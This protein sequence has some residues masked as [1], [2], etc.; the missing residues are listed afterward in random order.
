MTRPAATLVDLLRRRADDCGERVAF[1]FLADGEREA[2]S[3]TYGELDRRAR[4]LALRLGE[5]LPAGGRAILAFPPGLEFLAAFFGCLYA[6]VIAVPVPPAHP[7]RG[8]ERL[9][10]VAQD[11]E[12]G[13]VLGPGDVASD[14]GAENWRP[15][16]LDS[17]QLALLQYTSG[18]T[19]APRGVKISHG[20]IL[21]N[22]A[23][24]QAAQ[25]TEAASRSV[26]WLP[27][28]HDM[29]L[30][31]GLLAPLHGAY[32]AW[33]MS[34]AAFLN[35]TKFPGTTAKMLNKL[36]NILETMNWWRRHLKIFV[37]E[38]GF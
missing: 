29:G 25:A 30:I 32:P 28:Y 8:S 7:R 35:R 21:A 5:R 27:H 33:L 26:C 9:D 36:W 16:R 2:A 4:A 34:P 24:I 31:E 12:P 14:A 18:S 6:G 1:T 23:M 3:W 11:C 37:C 13:A 15:P 17:A 38:N 20:N 10:A 22:L 19:A